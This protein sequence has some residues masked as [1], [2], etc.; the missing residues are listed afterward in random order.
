[1]PCFL[2]NE[3]VNAVAEHQLLSVLI[4]V[5]VNSGNILSAVRKDRRCDVYSRILCHENEKEFLFLFKDIL[6]QKDEDNLIEKAFAVETK[7]IETQLKVK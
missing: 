1:M 6:W 5:N 2:L 4:A 3:E 7:E